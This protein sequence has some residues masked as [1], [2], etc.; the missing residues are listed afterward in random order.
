L[1][2]EWREENKRRKRF[3]RLSPAGQLILDQ[4]TDELHRINVSL[5][6]ITAES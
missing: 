3:Y 4:L 1:Q 2:S 6:R 5:E